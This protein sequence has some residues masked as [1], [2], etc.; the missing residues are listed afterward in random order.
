[1]ADQKKRHKRKASSPKR[2]Q[3]AATLRPLRTVLSG[4]NT[5]TIVGHGNFFG[6]VPDSNGPN[7]MT[8]DGDINGTVVM[9]NRTI[10][11]PIKNLRV[12]AY[13]E[14]GDEKG[15]KRHKSASWSAGADFSV[16]ITGNI[17][18]GLQTTTGD[19][20]VSGN[21]GGSAATTLGNIHIKGDVGGHASSTTGRVS[22]SK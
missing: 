18:G 10:S 12:T 4:V 15:A 14:E 6:S 3:V 7:V 20:T 21:V 19:I 13:W 9:G 17:S 16:T 8:V 22:V 1:M 5:G 2:A 11:R